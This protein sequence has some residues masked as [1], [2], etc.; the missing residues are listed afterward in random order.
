MQRELDA[1]NAHPIYP[2][3]QA[4]LSDFLEKHYLPWCN[5][6]AAELIPELIKD[7]S[8]SKLIQQSRETIRRSRRVMEDRA[9]NKR[10]KLAAVW[11]SLSD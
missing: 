3:G 8:T 11:R 5:Q 4:S 9:E 6:E 10:L 1:M 2:S 7:T